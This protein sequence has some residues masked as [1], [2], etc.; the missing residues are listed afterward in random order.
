MKWHRLYKESDAG[1]DL[2]ENIRR[3]IT[4]FFDLD[5]NGNP[6]IPTSDD[7][8]LDEIEYSSEVVDRIWELVK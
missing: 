5:E 3:I 7:V 2:R 8:G 4:T 6:T 1:S